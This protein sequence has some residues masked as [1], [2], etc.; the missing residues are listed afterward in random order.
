M[1]TSSTQISTDA[2]ISV[3]TS[4]SRVSDFK[5]LLKPGISAFVVVTGVAG[6]LLGLDG[7]IDWSVLIGLMLGTGLTAGGSGALNHVV[8]HRHDALMERTKDRPIP[9]GRLSQMNGAIYGI[10]LLLLGTLVLFLTTNALTAGLA[11]T[12]GLLYVLVYTPMKRKTALNTFVGAIPGALPILGGYTAATGVLGTMGWAVFAIL[13]LWQLPHFYAL[14]WMLRE[15][16]EKGGFVMLPSL[17]ASGKSTA[18][19]A[20]VATVLLAIAG[21]VPTLLGVSGW[22]YL[23]GMAVVGIVFLIPAISFLKERTYDRAKKLMFASIVY[24]P[25]FFALVVIDYIL[26]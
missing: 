13:F 16:Y 6:Y 8:E 14:A 7:N 3:T 2:E 9:S 11:F 1:R 25:V 10:A 18:T 5:E 17:D 19:H 20:L 21:I 24:V 12:T 22:L 26:R 23:I 15:D 4:R